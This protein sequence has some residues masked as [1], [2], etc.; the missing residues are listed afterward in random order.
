MKRRVIYVHP[1]TLLDI[2]VIYDQELPLT[3]IEWAYQSSSLTQPTL[4]TVHKIGNISFSDPQYD[5]TYTSISGKPIR[6]FWQKL[7]QEKS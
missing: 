4:L 7:P 3:K 5:F 6:N 2:R 1:N